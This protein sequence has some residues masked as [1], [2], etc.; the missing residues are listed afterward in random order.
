M[1][2]NHQISTWE[3]FTKAL[4]LRFGPPEFDNHQASLFK[5]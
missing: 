3:A 2:N 4:E 5:L 1:T